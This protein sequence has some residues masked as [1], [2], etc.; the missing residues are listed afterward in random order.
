MKEEERNAYIA[1]GIFF[2]FGILI[3][4]IGFDQGWENGKMTI[5]IGSFMTIVGGA[6]F[7]YPGIAE[8]LLQ[9]FRNAQE[10]Q[11][12]ERKLE[13]KQK[14]TSNSS[15]NMASKGG[16]IN[17]TYVNNYYSNSSKKSKKNYKKK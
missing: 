5:I 8:I 15:Q 6:G 1:T 14:N 10:A 4:V 3:F 7:K 9:Y 17:N 13:Q 11:E 16:K 2:L 12:R